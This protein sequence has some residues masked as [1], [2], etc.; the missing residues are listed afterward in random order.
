MAYEELKKMQ[1]KAKGLSEADTVKE[2]MKAPKVDGL[3]DMKISKKEMK[4]KSKP[5]MGCCGSDE[6]YPYGLEIRLDNES[7]EKLGIALPDVGKAVTITAKAMVTEASARE[8]QGDEGKRLSCT[9][10]IQKLK[11]G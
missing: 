6:R 1:A 4:E 11:V 7:M 3:T 9:L 8:T 10:Q 2:S 5:S